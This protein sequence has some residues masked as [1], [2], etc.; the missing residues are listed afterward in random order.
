MNRDKTLFISRFKYL[1]EKCDEPYKRKFEY[2]K[3][4]EGCHNTIKDKK[5]ISSRKKKEVVWVYRNP[6][7]DEDYCHCC[8]RNLISKTSFEVGHIVSYEQGGS[9]KLENL[10]TICKDCNK[11]MGT[12]CMYTFMYNKPE[13]RLPSYINDWIKKVVES[14]NRLRD[15][16]NKSKKFLVD[17]SHKYL[18]E[19][20]LSLTKL[21][22]RDRFEKPKTLE[23]YVIMQSKDIERHKKAIMADILDQYHYYRYFFN[24]IDRIFDNSFDLEYLEVFDKFDDEPL[25]RELLIAYCKNI[26]SC[27]LTIPSLKYNI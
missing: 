26:R 19:S 27:Y 9:E 16:F 5:P 7:S 15:F 10:E 4:I 8:H 25:K 12:T 1:C 20:I 21:I 11:H 6:S 18:E 2:N 22:N 13:L 23:N 14:I 17:Y 3:H 24:L